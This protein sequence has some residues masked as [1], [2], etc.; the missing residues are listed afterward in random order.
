MI[1]NNMQY[2]IYFRP[3]ALFSLLALFSHCGDHP[4]ADAATTPETPSQDTAQVF[5]LK[6]DT[7]KKSVELPGELLPYLQTDLFATVQG[8]VQAINADTV[9]GVH[10]GQTLAVFA[11]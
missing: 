6:T 3:L 10:R 2:S 4:K 7:L 5:L 9:D 8:Y 1:V 11:P